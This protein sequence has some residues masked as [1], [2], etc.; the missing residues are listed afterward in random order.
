MFNSVDLPVLCVPRTV[1]TN[2]FGDFFQENLFLKRFSKASITSSSHNVGTDNPSPSSSSLE[3]PF[4][5]SAAAK[6]GNSLTQIAN[7]S[8]RHV[9]FLLAVS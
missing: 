4:I 7:S 5:S 9:S 1:K 2:I 6:S 3:K 8:I